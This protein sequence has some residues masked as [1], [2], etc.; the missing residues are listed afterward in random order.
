MINPKKTETQLK[1]KMIGLRK[2]LN[3]LEDKRIA[4]ELNRYVSKYYK[5]Q[6]CYSGGKNW[7]EYLKV[8][9]LNKENNLECLLFSK[10]TNNLWHIQITYISMFYSSVRTEWI[11]TTEQ[12]FTIEWKKML[13][14]INSYYK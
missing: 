5:F 4:K 7:F 8:L 3:K 10:D 13:S 2:E 1:N 6:N 9:N 11:E 12:E 14:E